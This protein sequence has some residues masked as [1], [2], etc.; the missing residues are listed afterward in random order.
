MRVYKLESYTLTSKVS[1][2]KTPN[3]PEPSAIS[4]EQALPLLTYAGTIKRSSNTDE[5]VNVICKE[6]T[7][8]LV[9]VPLTDKG[10]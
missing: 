2:S 5:L 8:K 9:W 1:E 10:G 6:N 3:S 7:F 4:V